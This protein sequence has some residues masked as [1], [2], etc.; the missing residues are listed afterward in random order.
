ML[1]MLFHH[2]CIARK[3]TEGRRSRRLRGSCDGWALIELIGVLAILAILV[4]AGAGV[5]IAYID[6]LARDR[7]RE[8][9]KDLAE[10]LRRSVVQ[11]LLIPDEREYATQI[12]GFSGQPAAGV[13]I[14]PR[15][16]AR[17]LL[18]DPEVTNSGFNLP[19]DQTAAPLLG[20]G[21]GTLSNVRMLLVSS[22]G[23]FL[24]KTLPAAPGGRPTATVFS[25]LWETPEGRVPTG[26][27]WRGDPHDFFLQRIQFLDLF[28]PVALNHAEAT[29]PFTNGQ[30]RLPGMNAFAPP[31]GAPLPCV[32]WL[33]Q[34][35][36]LVLSNETDS[37][38]LSEIVREP[39]TFTY[40]RGRWVRGTGALVKG[41]GVQSPLSGA[42]FE[43]AVRRFLESAAFADGIIV[44]SAED[45]PPGLAKKI[46]EPGSPSILLPSAK[47]VVNAMSNYIRFG[48]TGPA[49]KVNM[50]KA[51]NNYRAALI[52]YTGLPP[53]QFEKP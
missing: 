13:L 43:E 22:L 5:G 28:E 17:L 50:F 48:A 16:N 25:N 38:L 53:G 8:T 24:P 30:V 40:E 34:G 29:G 32:H 6:Q 4:V 2:P 46:T 41:A 31:T 7:E 42:D 9:L 21:T 12:A 49:E 23:N 52:D 14:N 47:A 33:L 26:L 19:F 45:L 27:S 20:A 51:V 39:L 36:T 11:D 1:L 10:A 44:G 15:G 37:S 35:T 18:I 3:P